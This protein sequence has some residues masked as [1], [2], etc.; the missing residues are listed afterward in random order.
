MLSNFGDNTSQYERQQM[1]RRRAEQ[2]RREA[3]SLRMYQPLPFQEEFHASRCQQVLIQKA[4]RVGGTVA[5]MVEVARA[6]TGQD[7]YQKYA[8]K[9]GRIVC[10]GY[11]EKHI[12]RVFYE[13]LFRPGAFRVIR[14]L[15][16]QKWR[17][18]RPWPAAEGG[19]L[20]RFADSQKAPPMIPKR[21]IE[22]IAWEKRSERVFSIVTGTT[23]WE[24][25]ATNS[26]GD[27]GQAQGFDVDLY[28]IDE[29]LATPGWLEEAQGRVAGCGGLIRWSAL[30]H[31]KNN[32][33]MGLVKLA[34]DQEGAAKPVAK[35]IRATIFDNH[36]LPKDSVANSVA[37]WK[38]KGEDVYRKR[39]LGEININSLLM[40]PTFN[41]DVH[42][43]MRITEHSSAAQKMLADRDGEPP[44]DWARYVSIDPGYTALAI[45]FLAVPP[46]ALGNQ[47][48]LYD[49]VFL[50]E[51]AV[52][53]EAFGEAMQMKC[54]DHCFEAFIMDMHGARLR[55]IATGEL[56]I[57]KYRDALATR[58]IESVATKSGFRSACDDRKLREEVLR[59]LLALNRDGRP[60]FMVVAGKCQ[61][62]CVEMENFQKKKVK[63]HGVEFPID[64]GDRRTNTHAIEAVEGALG[65][66]LEYV[67]PR[68]KTVEI[69]F[70]ERWEAFRAKLH[71]K[72][73]PY[74]AGRTITLGPVGANP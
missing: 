73:A 11:G 4:N 72:S 39:A 47:V 63:Q 22:S 14:D 53:A 28:A 29:D 24:I 45:E 62:F 37:A 52:P 44:D 9:N 1:V 41:R 12:G 34:R 56:P 6:F 17:V 70:V 46:P 64:E 8:E 50:R 10:L 7:P 3:E 65:L 60:L 40:Y 2:L 69:N 5:L 36:Y 67:E 18:Y 20:E 48:F 74:A 38:A 66:G 13:K 54:S 35:L 71:A 32:D 31:A 21:F 26:A 59:T 33:L 49:E 55:S 16:T 68:T 51:P 23:G 61:T 42:D 25:H 58:R 57:W 19:D 15:E 43:V 30:P 27:P